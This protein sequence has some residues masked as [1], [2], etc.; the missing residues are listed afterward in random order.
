[1]RISLRATLPAL[2][3]ALSPPLH[4]QRDGSGYLFGVPD[5]RFNV[6]AGYAH[7]SANSDIFDFATKFLTLSRR[8]FSGPRSRPTW[9]GCCSVR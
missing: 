3:L 1:M 2:L 8:S 7:A 9:A 5:V 4:A 6:R